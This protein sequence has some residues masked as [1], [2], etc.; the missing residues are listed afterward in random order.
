MNRR[1]MKAVVSTNSASFCASPASILKPKLSLLPSTTPNTNTAM[2]PLACRP[3]GGEIGAD[4]RDQRDHRRVFG[5]ERPALMGDQQRGQI[6]ERRCRRRMPIA[7]CSKRSNSALARA[8]TR[9]SRSQAPARVKVTIA[10]MASLKADLA[11]HGL[12]DPVA[13][14]DLPE[15]RHQR[16]GIGRGER[17][18]EQERRRSCGRLEDRSGPRAR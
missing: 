12:R 8:R 7:D 10:P 15:D 16:R 3:L 4:H 2:K 17:R 18:A 6:A 5:Q 1:M 13:D 11:H 14:L 9:R